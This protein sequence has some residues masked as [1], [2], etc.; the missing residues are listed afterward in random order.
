MQTTKFWSHCY[1]RTERPLDR[2][3]WLLIKPLACAYEN[4]TESEDHRRDGCAGVV[5]KP[6]DSRA[7]RRVAWEARCLAEM[8][9]YRG[10]CPLQKS[11]DLLR[12]ECPLWSRVHGA[13]LTLL[14][15]SSGCGRW[16]QC[17]VRIWSQSKARTLECA[18]RSWLTDKCGLG[19]RI[20]LTSL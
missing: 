10:L 6:R 9:H 2:N 20:R 19:R 11:V 4:K 1:A 13:I 14:Q 3:A 17:S 15:H 12:L 8:Q 7:S 16:P 5:T 18:G